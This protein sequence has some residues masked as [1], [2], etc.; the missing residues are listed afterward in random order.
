VTLTS[1]DG[2]SDLPVEP[3]VEVLEPVATEDHPPSLRVT[4]SNTGE[5][6]LTVG[7]GRA[8]RF[9]YVS[10]DSGTLQLLPAEGEYPVPE[11]NCWRLT[12][13]VATTM[14]YRTDELEPGEALEAD[15]E[16][17]ALP[18][19]DGCLPVGEFRF[20]TAYTVSTGDPD[21]DAEDAERATWGFSVSLE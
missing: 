1:V 9:Q 21:A 12:E 6:A 16:L 18:G 5:G 20:E 19:Y 8:I 4:L 10:D 2:L 17:Y 13:G 3:G 15:V 7:E 11:G 14:E